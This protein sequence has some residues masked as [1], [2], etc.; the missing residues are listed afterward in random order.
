ML[1]LRPAIRYLR[2][3]YP[4]SGRPL[5]RR[6][7]HR[8]HC[9]DCPKARLNP[10]MKAAPPIAKSKKFG[11]GTSRVTGNLAKKGK[12]AN[13]TRQIRNPAHKLPVPETLVHRCA[14][15]RAVT[16]H[17]QGRGLG[18]PTQRS[19]HTARLFGSSECPTTAQWQRPALVRQP[20]RRPTCRQH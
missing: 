16:L 11:H 19:R 18:W 8:A 12:L 10:T 17:S 9:C 7:S 3:S 15:R 1:K 5:T 14:S 2:F 4:D 20:V 6:D 13:P